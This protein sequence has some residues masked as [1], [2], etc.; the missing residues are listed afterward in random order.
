MR[1]IVALGNVDL[2]AR[3]M[4]QQQPP[5]PR[6]GA[7]DA[8]SKAGTVRRRRQVMQGEGDSDNERDV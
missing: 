1:D 5:G 7:L 6:F 8:P 4:P 3:F 2:W